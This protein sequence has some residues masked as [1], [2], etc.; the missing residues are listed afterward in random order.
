MIDPSVLLET[1]E[2]ERSTL[3]V[4]PQFSPIQW[5]P[6]TQSRPHHHMRVDLRRRHILVPQKF[7]HRADEMPETF[8]IQLST[9]NRS[10]SRRCPGLVH[11]NVE[12]SSPPAQRPTFNAE[13]EA[14]VRKLAAKMRTSSSVSSTSGC[15]NLGA[16]KGTR[17]T[18]RSHR[19]DSRSSL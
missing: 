13:R 10:R 3:N 16:S 6:H 15:T 9:L 18:S 14:A 11:G 1:L 12:R 5:T 19:R 8:N 7:L 2:V 4:L 17:C